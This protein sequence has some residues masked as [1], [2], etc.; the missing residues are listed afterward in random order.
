M[1]QC[2]PF[3]GHHPHSRGPWHRARSTRALLHAPVSRERAHLTRRAAQSQQDFLLVWTHNLKDP[4]QATSANGARTDSRA[5]VRRRKCS[6]KFDPMGKFVYIAQTEKLPGVPGN[7]WHVRPRRLWRLL[8]RRTGR[9]RPLPN[10]YFPDAAEPCPG[11]GPL[12]PRS[13]TAKTVHRTGESPRFSG[14]SA[15]PPSCRFAASARAHATSL[16]TVSGDA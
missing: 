14:P 8:R 13:K 2:R 1:I 3:T 15:T 4:I 7:G 12:R 11:R 10:R 6:I 16:A 5:R 9:R